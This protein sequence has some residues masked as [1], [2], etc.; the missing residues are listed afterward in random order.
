MNGQLA[1]W[2]ELRHDTLLYAK[3]SYTAWPVCEFPDAYVDPYPELWA[4][5]A[6][7]AARG[8]ALVNTLPAETRGRAGTHFAELQTVAQRL[9]DMARRQLTGQ[10]FTA[11]Q[12][13]WV[14]EAVNIKEVPNCGPPLQVPDGWYVRLFY[15]AETVKEED[16]TIADVHTQPADAG[17]TPVGKV[18]HVG[19]GNPRLMVMT[20][21]TCVGPRA[22]VGLVSAYYE[23]VTMAFQRLTD[24][25]WAEQLKQSPPDVPWMTDLVRR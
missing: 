3:Q 1:S 20:A 8:L 10:T 7:Y 15:E 23:K 19:T 4:A 16:P 12:L 14:N 25:E 5:L 21:E 13:A 11:D 6:K 22:Y 9:E 17:G 2:A 18:L 24:Q